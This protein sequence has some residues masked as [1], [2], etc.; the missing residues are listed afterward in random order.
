LHSN[1]ERGKKQAR[2]AGAERACLGVICTMGQGAIMQEGRSAGASGLSGLTTDTCR[3]GAWAFCLAF[4]IALAAIAQRPARAETLTLDGASPAGTVT[5]SGTSLPAQYNPVNVYAGVLDWTSST[6]TPGVPNVWTYC[7]DVAAIIN[8]NNSYTYSPESLSFSPTIVNAI[9]W[10]WDDST[11]AN[12]G[13]INS[14]TNVNAISAEHAAMLQ[15]A[16]WDVIYNAGS[17]SVSNTALSFANPG[18]GL[19]STDLTNALSAAHTDYQNGVSGPP[20]TNVPELTELLATSGQNQVIF[21]G[22]APAPSLP[23]PKSSLGGL[24]LLGLLGIGCFCRR[25]QIA[26]DIR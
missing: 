2:E 17:S 13:Q 6:G 15:V 19:T 10:L 26:D 8:V 21:I 23:L 3:G 22:T 7:I 20:V 4:A 16:L 5:L 25:A 24:A 11:F 1:T 9:Q 12:A 14:Q 18:N